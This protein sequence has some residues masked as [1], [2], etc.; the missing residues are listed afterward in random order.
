[1]FE[2]SY[3]VVKTEAKR[4]FFENSAKGPSVPRSAMVTFFSL[5][6][7]HV[8]SLSAGH[9]PD[10]ERERLLKERELT[11]RSRWASGIVCAFVKAEKSI[12]CSFLLSLV[13]SQQFRLYIPVS[14]S[15]CSAAKKRVS[16]QRRLMALFPLFALSPRERVCTRV[17][18]WQ[19]TSSLYA[20]D[21]SKRAVR[22]ICRAEGLKRGGGG[23]DGER[24][25]E[26]VCVSCLPP[27]EQRIQCC[28]AAC[29]P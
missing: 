6:L 26:C 7:E 11:A 8:I 16:C 21:S 1:M 17:R 10:R 20:A 25:K 3:W 13:P 14:S 24:E 29:I 19:G 4:V 27:R 2:N 18:R 15:G 5:K 12:R 28:A 9:R 23:G 22:I